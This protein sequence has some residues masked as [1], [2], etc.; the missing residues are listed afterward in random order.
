MLKIHPAC[1][2]LL[3]LIMTS[4]EISARQPQ[5]SLTDAQEKTLFEMSL[6]ELLKVKVVSASKIDT[7]IA[8]AP[9]VSSL[10][11]RQDLIDYGFTHL[12]DLLYTLP[13]FT[14]SQDYDRPTVAFRGNSDSWSNNHL[15]HLV[16]GIPVNDNLYG[17]AYTWMTPVF[18][19][20]NVEVNRGPGS[21]LYGS[22]ATNGVVQMN[23]L[24][25]A[26]L[27]RPFYARVTLDGTDNK[28]RHQLMGGVSGDRFD[29]IAAYHHEENP[30]LSVT[31]FDGSGRLQAADNPV[32]G[33]PQ[34]QS[35]SLNNENSNQYLWSKLTLDE[36]WQ[37]QLHHQRWDF[38][39]GH[40]WLFWIPDQEESME[41]YRN[42]LSLGYQ[43]KSEGQTRE[44][45]LR[46]Q[47]HH[48][49]WNQRYYPDQAFDNYYPFGM[50]EYLRSNGVDW[51]L[52]AQHTYFMSEQAT[53]LA[54][55]ETD[56]F[57]YRG[58][59]SHSANINL[60]SSDLEPY[61]NGQNQP[62]GS[63]LDYLLDEPVVNTALFAQLTTGQWLDENLE[64][65]LGMR[66]DQLQVDYREI[67]QSP[68]SKVGKKW[69]QLS[70]KIAAVWSITPDYN[71][72][73]LWSKAFR[74][75]TPT[76]MGGA[77]TFSLASNIAELAPE[78]IDS[79][80]LGGH[81]QVNNNQQFIWSSF[82]TEFNN[83]IAY[84][85][86]NFNLSTNL[87]STKNAGLE[88]EWLTSYESWKW[89][90]NL[91]WVKRLDEQILAVDSNGDPE[92]TSHPNDLVWEPTI[93]LNAGVS[94]E[95]SDQWQLGLTLH[96]QNRVNRRDNEVGNPDGSLPFGVSVP[97][98]YNLDDH[99]PRQLGGYTSLNSTS[100][101]QLSDKLSLQFNVENLL[102]KKVYLVKTGPYPFDYPGQ[103]RQV[104]LQLNLSF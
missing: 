28:T 46:Y 10:I 54:G 32:T 20:R 49:D 102:D 55:L 104:S 81:W 71:M 19:S 27:T 99:R 7:E 16:D 26:D 52:R 85:T 70:P 66:Y 45:L 34:S 90:A 25:A 53:F 23:T 74:A 33:R 100:K 47:K 15:L 91:S 9:A 67:N 2:L 51:L 14:P 95:L 38:Q 37:L 3:T 48:I 92:L 84:S 29:L 76:E 75:P 83:Q 44:Y 42:L 86:A 12:N 35:F 41:E 78:K 87:L 63:W 30:S 97:E 94:I 21:A 98:N 13:G 68:V 61:P 77:H 24:N 43:K 62:Q 93:K 82:V 22:F 5:V 17:T 11:T 73:F 31:S 103:Q 96:C 101:Y 1:K 36:K 72:K 64:L 39:T 50:W 60:D 59:E 4:S 57:I 40:G 88:L 65:T 56:Y 80:E 89:F 58:D 6:D 79:F 69:S 8:K 18:F